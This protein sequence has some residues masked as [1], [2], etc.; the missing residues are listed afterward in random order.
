MRDDVTGPQGAR[1]DSPLGSP[2]LP[3]E[4]PRWVTFL[5]PLDPGN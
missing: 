5:T 2:V 3:I 4:T 1:L